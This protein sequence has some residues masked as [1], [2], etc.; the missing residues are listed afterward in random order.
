MISPKRK[1]VLEE[2]EK[3]KIKGNKIKCHSCT[4]EYGL[5][6]TRVKKPKFTPFPIWEY[7]KV[8]L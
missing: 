5:D 7:K 6:T 4:P 2:L 8:R 3:L 1:K